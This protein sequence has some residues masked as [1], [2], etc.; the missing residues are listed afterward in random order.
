MKKIRVAMLVND[1]NMNGISKVADS[2]CSNIDRNKFEVSV[3]AGEPVSEV[4]I[5]KYKELG[6]TIKTLPNRKR[7]SLAYYK[8]L[9]KVLKKGRYDIVHIHGN[10][11]T[12]TAELLIAAM[13][14]IKVRIAHS[15]NTTCSFMKAHRILYPFFKMLCTHRLACGQEAGEWLFRVSPFKVLPNGFE[16]ERFRYS[17]EK[18]LEVRKANHWED[19]YVIGHIG[20]FNYQKNHPYLLK[21][22][23]ETAKQNKDAILLLIGAGGDFESVKKLID[24]HPYKDRIV[25]YGETNDTP[26]VYMAMDVFCLPSRFEG[27]PVVLL[28]AQMT[29]L[30]CVASD[31]IT[32]EVDFGNIIWEDINGSPKKWADALLSAPALNRKEYFDTHTAQ[33]E[34]YD[35]LKNVKMLEKFY[36]DAL[37][38]RH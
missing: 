37:K 14:G 28:E 35:I 23:E 30:S 29:G 2:Y 32:N 9:F 4:Y 27:L 3:I 12:I 38:S 26:S 34:K 10:S 18:R 22:F 17:E 20:R 25:I 21:V 7:S 36:I 1:F 19:K 11:A 24:A 5:E 31:T 13:C 6:V 15:H 16:V 8:A 33:I